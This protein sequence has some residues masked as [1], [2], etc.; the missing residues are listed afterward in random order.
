MPT[1]KEYEKFSGASSREVQGHPENNSDC[2]VCLKIPT[3]IGQI[4]ISREGN[5]KS[6][7]L[8]FSG[9]KYVL[10]RK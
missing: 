6:L 9:K 7:I 10:S 5:N 2:L 1:F 3:D 8:K 4:S